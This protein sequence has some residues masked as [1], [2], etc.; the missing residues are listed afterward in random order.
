MMGGEAG[1]IIGDAT[2]SVRR[3]PSLL[4][5][6]TRFSWV[7]GGARL[8][9]GPRIEA[10]R[11]A[12]SDIEWMSVAGGVRQC[13]LV[14]IS[15]K[16]FSAAKT[17]WLAHRLSAVGLPGGAGVGQS[18]R[19]YAFVGQRSSIR[20]AEEAWSARDTD[21][22]GELF[23]YPQC[24]CKFFREAWVE[25][26]WHDT[27]WPMAVDQMLPYRNIVDVEPIDPPVANILLRWLGVRA[28]PH[29]PCRFY[30]QETAR[31]GQQ[32]LSVGEQAGYG[33]EMQWLTEI[34]SWPVEWSA[35]HGI[36]E[37]KMPILK[38][39]TR[40]DATASKCTVRWRGE[41]YPP[42]G[43]S[44]LHFPY[45]AVAQLTATSGKGR[46][47][48][49][50][51]KKVVDTARPTILDAT[52]QA[53][54]R[55]ARD[56]RHI[57]RLRLSNY[58][59]VVELDDGSIGAAMNFGYRVGAQLK[60]QQGF[61]ERARA[62]DPLLLATTTRSNDLLCLSLRVAIV[63]ALSAP[64]LRAANDHRFTASCSEPTCL[65]DGVTTAIV[66]GF[67]GYMHALARCTTV[68]NLH[69]ADLQY[70]KRRKE[71]DATVIRYRQERPELEMTISDGSDTLHHMIGAD[72]VC[73]SG[74]TLCNG[75]LDGLLQ[76][77]ESCSRI[78][79]QGQ[80]ASIHP[81]ELFRRGVTAICTTLKP[82][83]LIDLADRDL[84]GTVLEGSLPP[85]YLTPPAD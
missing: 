56:V 52:I 30:C 20:R 21:T 41:I 72:L 24:C 19:V 32:L 63:S 47:V 75:T 83:N 3:I 31:F 68:R 61:L 5:D 65:F 39:V 78:V 23:G 84:L 81:A 57:T 66:I 44:G 43:A 6:F 14:A 10:I 59:N 25:Q 11:R 40:T 74:S 54:P 12:W 28:V 34:L 76:N 2:G 82:S 9:W 35:L 29:L 62:H 53:L 77:A 27:T 37:I 80:S 33:Q 51:G 60:E 73:I 42:E 17:R 70:A 67:G 46:A 38:I 22:L 48:I 45:R 69:V 79:I 7:N 49:E 16:A 26:H 55:E 58:F 71:M 85:I 4:P 50:R 13:A 15:Q 8:H 1:R 64:I 36:A 18:G